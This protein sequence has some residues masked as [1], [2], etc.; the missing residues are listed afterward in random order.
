MLQ[1]CSRR[2]RS[3]NVDLH[4]ETAQREIQ[5]EI[6]FWILTNRTTWNFVWFSENYSHFVIQ[7][8]GRCFWD[9]CSF[10]SFR[11]LGNWRS[12]SRFFLNWTFTLILWLLA[13]WVFAPGVL[14]LTLHLLWS[15]FSFVIRYSL[16]VLVYLISIQLGFWMYRDLFWISGW[17]NRSRG[18]VAPAQ[19]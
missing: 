15:N 14:S 9:L 18:Y 13:F 19:G 1:A 3:R 10:F 6:N 8:Y 7:Q 11:F 5:K 17:I 12:P 2:N 4:K 16:F